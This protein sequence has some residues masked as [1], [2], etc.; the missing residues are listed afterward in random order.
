VICDSRFDPV[1]Q[2]TRN[3]LT[4]I[5]AS[6]ASLAR[7]VGEYRQYR[8]LF[9]FLMLRDIMLRYRQ[10]V[11]GVLWAVLQPILPVVIFTAVF[12][13]VLRPETGGVPYFLFALAGLAPWTFFANAITASG[14]SF[15]NNHNLLNKVYFPRAILPAASVA[16][17]LLDWLVVGVFLLGLVLWRG[18]RPTSEWLI[19]PVI[20]AL[21]TI[22][23]MAVGLALASL[24]AMYR[25]VKHV[26]P[27][28]VQLWMYAT[29]VVYPAKLLPRQ[30]HWAIALNPMTAVVEGFRSCLFGTPVDW[31]L[32]EVSA[33]SAVLIGVAAALLFHRL[34]ADL[35]ER[36]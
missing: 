27:F 20:V 13:R 11:L 3:A 7:K 21:T 32:L 9:F 33:L 4:V 35:A 29:P 14:S 8:T 15:I 23:A 17:C 36:V 28:V 18:Y 16:A 10:T 26:L 24:M 6:G 25:D 34:E 1:P 30:L 2:S 31:N 5:D 19:L 22:L 12:A